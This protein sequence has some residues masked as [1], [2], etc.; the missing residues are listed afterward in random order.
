[1]AD[2]TGEAK[3]PP[4]RV[5]FD[6]R[7]KLEFHGARITSDGGLLAYRELDDVFDLT[8]MGA[9]ALGEGRRGRNIRHRL[10]GLLRQAVYGRLAGYE[11]VNDAE[12]LA[13]DPVMRAIVGREGMDRPAASTSQMGRFETEWLASE[14]NLAALTDLSGAWIDR[15]HV[16]RPPDGIILDM[17]SSESPTHGQQEG[18]AWNGHFGCTCYHPL[19]VFNQFGDL[20]RCVLRPGNAHSAEGWRSVLEPVIARY[21]ERG[22]PL[23]FRGD[24]AFAKP[25][26]YELLEAEGIG[27][28]I[29]MPANTVLQERIGH[30]L[31]RPVGRPPKKPQ[32]FFASFSYQAQSWARPRRVVA[33]MGWTAPDGVAVPLCGSWGSAEKEPP[34]MSI[35]MIGL[36]TAKSV[37]QVHAVDEAGTTAVR[38]KLRR[39]ELIMFFEKQEACTVVMEACGAAHH[40]ARVLIGLGHEVK[41]VAP[42]AI[43][44]FVKKGKK[45]DAADAAAICQ[46]ACRPDIRFVPVKSLEQQGILA[47]HSARSL[48]VKQKTMLANAMRGLAT[49]FGVT[50]PRGIGRLEELVVLADVGNALPGRARQVIKDLLEHCR[51]LAASIEVLEAEI[52]AHARQDEAARRLATIPGVGPITA[53]LMA[54]TVADIGLFKSARQFAAW[55]G[56]VPRQYSTGGKTRLG[57][58]TKAGNREL[59]KSLVLGATSMV[60]RAAAW[61]SAAGVWTRAILERRPVRLVTVALANKMARIA[62]ALMTRKEIYHPNAPVTVEAQAVA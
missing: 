53:S 11:D 6:R 23:W 16:R 2:A 28:A 44:P 43:K 51:I 17:D 32:V 29:R 41:L 14:A 8:A 10:P 30:L 20:E 34:A 4:L 18:S 9:S 49:E 45:N 36:D 7:I 5:A 48:L 52:V 39:S 1:M 33:K 56:L 57:R 3:E 12:R 62:W 21:R 40:W 19:F 37:F 46:A 27:Y 59:R 22:L 35:A 54:A 55:L 42:E 58:I 13:R 50:V 26:L 15:V 25:E 47:V 61:N 24:A 60:Y 31:T 38:R